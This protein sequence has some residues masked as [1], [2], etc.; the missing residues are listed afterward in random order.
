M[1]AIDNSTAATT[2]P[3]APAVGPNPGG[4]W[5]SGNPASSTPATIVDAWFLEMLQQ[6]LLNVAA[7]A[8]VTPSKANNAQLLAA[9]QKLIGGTLTIGSNYYILKTLCPGSPSGF[10]YEVGGNASL[11]ASG[12]ATASVIV[13]LPITFN[14]IL[15]GWPL[16]SA[17]GDAN[18]TEGALVAPQCVALSNSQIKIDADTLSGGSDTFNETVACTYVV[19]GY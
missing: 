6:E 14:G 10:L 7:A 9:I 15:Y 16:A 19:K 2:A 3:A 17:Y 13:T 18:G 1:Y 4:H 12:N 8:G 5:T 11:P